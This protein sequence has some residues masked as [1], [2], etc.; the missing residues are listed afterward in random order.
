MAQ[1]FYSNSWY[2]VA[3]LKPR[4]ASHVQIERQHFRG[5]LWYV[6]RDPAGQRFYRFNPTAYSV[7]GLMD[8]RRTVEEIFARAG[9]ALGA[10]APTQ[11][12]VVELLAKLSTAEALS[13]DGDGVGILPL[14]RRGETAAAPAH[15]RAL[16][17]FSWRFPLL[18]PTRVVDRLLPLV[19]LIFSPAGASLWLTAMVAAL[20]LGASH[21]QDLTHDVA[22]TILAPQ[23]LF[24]LWLL[25]PMLKL[26]HELGHA[27]ALRHFGGEVHELGI[28]VWFFQPVPYVDAA[29]AVAL[30]TKAHRLLVSAA[31]MMSELFIAAVALFVW[32]NVEPGLVRT[33]AYNVIFI[34]GVS[35]VVFNLNPLM[36]Y[37]GYY[38]LSDYLEIPNLYDRAQARWRALCER[39]LFGSPD[40]ATEMMDDSERLWLTLYPVASL[41]YRLFVYLS[42]ASFVATK[43]AFLGVILAFAVLLTSVLVPSLGFVIHLWKTPRLYGTRRRALLATTITLCAA[44]A[45]VFW[46][47]LPLRTRAE[48]VV[49]LPEQALVRANVDGFVERLSAQPGARVRQGEV[50]VVCRDPQLIRQNQALEHR[51]EELQ[52][53]YAALWLEDQRQAQVIKDEIAHV[54]ERLAHARRRLDALAIRSQSDGILYVPQGENLV[55]RFVQQGAKLAYVL[56]FSALTVR[57]VVPQSDADLVRH[58]TRHIDVRLADRTDRTLAAKLVREVPAASEQLPSMALGSQGGG[59]VVVD[60]TDLQ[61]TKALQKI[62]QFDLRLAPLPAIRTLGGRAYVRFDHGSE[63][64]AQRW[65]RQLRQLFLGKL[66]G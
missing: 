51:L 40:T 63:P 15:R 16:D 34:A 35:T 43:F 33:L 61:G 36:R 23:N 44:L 4:L 65:G 45:L 13:C 46:L 9:A 2:R 17:L 56:D 7:I 49:S 54:E 11:E 32:L 38:L 59:S 29:A 48:G 41:L 28:M 12:E 53:R 26:L 62:F 24:I 5:A 30:P 21:W 64:L 3:D 58:R 19:K 1:S 50:L 39:Y 42:L 66:D 47:P 20:L 55:G 8:G 6:L 25:F 57:V 52:T 60:P 27:C 31:G 18:D 22:G 10:S 37:D 14:Q